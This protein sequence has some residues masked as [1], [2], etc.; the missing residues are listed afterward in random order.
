MSGE[1]K[2]PPARKMARSSPA[3]PVDNRLKEVTANV[4]LDSAV[5]EDDDFEF[6]PEGRN[7]IVRNHKADSKVYS[8]HSKLEFPAV[9]ARGDGTYSLVHRRAKK[10]VS[11]L[12]SGANYFQVVGY[13]PVP[14]QVSEPRNVFITHVVK[15]IDAKDRDLRVPFPKFAKLVGSQR[16]VTGKARF[17]HGRGLAGLT[18]DI[19]HGNAMA[20]MSRRC[21]FVQW[22]FFV[23]NA[24]ARPNAWQ[25]FS[26]KTRWGM[27]PYDG[28]WSAI[29][30]ERWIYVY[31]RPSGENSTSP[32]WVEELHLA[33]GGIISVAP[34]SDDRNQDSKQPIGET[35]R[36][37]RRLLGVR[38]EHYFFA[39]RIR[40][41][42]KFA[43]ELGKSIHRYT[44]SV[45]FEADD[46]GIADFQNGEC[47]VAVLDPF[48]VALKL[49]RCLHAAL[50]NC[51]GYTAN[52]EGRPL[53]EKEQLERRM[54]RRLLGGLLYSIT[55]GG[56]KHANRA[57]DKL[58]TKKID[59]EDK[60][61]E[62]VAE[63]EL[64]MREFEDQLT[65]RNNL[66][67]LWAGLLVGW[68]ESEPVT[69]LT[70]AYLAL[71]DEY[72][73]KL[74]TFWGNTVWGL[75]ESNA[76]KN[77]LTKVIGD[78]SHWVHEVFP[79]SPTTLKLELIHQAI[80]KS[81]AAA[82][83]A[84][85]ELAKSYAF[86]KRL[87]EVLS[88]LNSTT[89]ATSGRSVFT[90]EPASAVFTTSD[91]TMREVKFDAI[92]A[93]EQIELTFTPVDYSRYHSIHRIEVSFNMLMEVINISSTIF[94]WIHPPE[95]NQ[96]GKAF[97]IFN[98]L[99]AGLDLGQS[100]LE[101][102]KFV[103][104][105]ISAAAQAETKALA[106]F[107]RSPKTIP[108][109]GLISSA[110]DTA[111]GFF[112]TIDAVDKGNIGAAYGSL[113]VTVGS[114][115]LMFGNFYWCLM[116][117]EAGPFGMVGLAIV[118]L[119]HLIKLFAGPEDS[120]YEKLVGH[121]D[122]GNGATSPNERPAWSSHEFKDWK[123]KLNVQ[124]T[125]AISLL[126]RPRF[127]FE[128]DD[129]TFFRL[130]FDWLPPGCKVDV[131]YEKAWDEEYWELA[132]S[133]PQVKAT[134]TITPDGA[135]SDSPMLTMIP[136]ESKSTAY[137]IGPTKLAKLDPITKHEGFLISSSGLKWMRVGVILEIDSGRYQFRYPIKGAKEVRLW[138][139]LFKS[140][141]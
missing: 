5:Q 24:V 125:A 105:K 81:G 107:F 9:R 16:Q 92:R 137:I 127:S 64:F 91:A 121:S 85:A 117:A 32:G 28:T 78:P 2:P 54:K 75:S 53:A 62:E 99:G 6:I 1:K 36:F 7:P 50:D 35:I 19:A 30:G 42:R 38:Q 33:E 79:P 93:T 70:R 45:N 39:T 112:D 126:C 124:L 109:I 119:G 44:V 63:L 136:A 102:D 20:I 31:R 106:N 10:A 43:I 131:L 47:L 65:L 74:V 90:K 122:W 87:S 141:A 114:G 88:V 11:T 97:T 77:Y 123:G 101:I 138:F 94:S 133:R 34:L 115:M 110:I 49:H 25:P 111:L 71:K 59:R 56:T 68:L 46:P 17:T 118:G 8:D 128:G 80:R 108:G 67:E 72:L 98:S 55:G 134:F 120:D 4:I 48:E 18:L 100:I 82:F 96:E 135:I 129:R 29:D 103:Q 66:R 27:D 116:A 40:L 14:Q 26:F 86:N 61:K 69:W 130:D 51:I 89:E 84:A 83:A 140:E 12:I 57:Y 15:T 13:K 37:P 22:N 104:D 52:Y 3:A 58:R 41:T 60:E 23:R 21:R 76:G 139:W 132:S 113:A 73:W 95:G